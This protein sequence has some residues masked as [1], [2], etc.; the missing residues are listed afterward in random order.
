M[1]EPDRAKARACYNCRRRRLRCD[2]SRPACRKCSTA[3]E[4]CLGYGTVL[5]WAN[6]PAIRGNLVGQLEVKSPRQTAE[7]KNSVFVPPALLD[8]LLN[9]LNRRARL[10]V[11]HCKQPGSQ[12]AHSRDVQARPRRC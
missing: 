3:G 6:A 7:P 5:R 2:R 12:T 4:E 1:P 10:Y 9:A 8:P 11:H